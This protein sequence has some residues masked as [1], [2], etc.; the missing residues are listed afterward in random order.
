[1]EFAL[2]IMCLPDKIEWPWIKP[3]FCLWGLDWFYWS[4][5]D[6]RQQPGMTACFSK[7]AH[8]VASKKKYRL[9]SAQQF[10]RL[11]SVMIWRFIL[12]CFRPCH[13]LL[14]LSV[15][16]PSCLPLF[17]FGWS[18]L[19]FLGSCLPMAQQTWF[20]FLLFLNISPSSLR[21]AV[22]EQKQFMRSVLEMVP[23]FV[24]IAYHC[25]PSFLCHRKS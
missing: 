24:V 14:F 17:P 20:I 18:L 25:E 11:L 2:V 8:C 6:W 13:F 7:Q 23:N 21:L 19:L 9:H 1:M 16:L 3:V 22:F 12:L 4:L 5:M 15:F 10:S